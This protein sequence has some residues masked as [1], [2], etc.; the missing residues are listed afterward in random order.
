MCCGFVE[1]TLVFGVKLTAGDQK[2][3]LDKGV[4]PRCGEEYLHNNLQHT[5]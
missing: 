5:E 3:C 2:G 4:V 1:R